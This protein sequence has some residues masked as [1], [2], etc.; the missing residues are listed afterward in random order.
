VGRTIKVLIEG[1]LVARPVLR[2]PILDGVFM[3]QMPGL[4]EVAAKRLAERLSSGGVKL[5]VEAAPQ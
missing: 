4:G 1:Q 3:F 5:E 2:E